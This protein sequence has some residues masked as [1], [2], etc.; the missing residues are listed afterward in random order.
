M[1][2]KSQPQED[3]GTERTASVRQDAWTRNWA[4]PASHVKNNW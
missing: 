4:G 2:V 1:M 3:L